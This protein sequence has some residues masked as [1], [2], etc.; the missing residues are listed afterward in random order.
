MRKLREEQM[1]RGLRPFAE[2]FGLKLW[3]ALATRPALYAFATSIA[4]WLLSACAGDKKRLA[5]LPF[6]SGWTATRDFPAPSGETFR[7]RVKKRQASR[8]VSPVRQATL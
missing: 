5:W 6:G 1:E 7:E 8:P 2:R 3:V 4:A